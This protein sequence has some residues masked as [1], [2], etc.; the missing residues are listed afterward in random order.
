[1]E[2]LTN[3]SVPSLYPEPHVIKING[4]SGKEASFKF[5][6]IHA[7]R[8]RMK[9]NEIEIDQDFYLGKYP[10]TQEQWMAIM[11]KNPSHFKGGRLPVETVSW[12]DVQTFIQKLNTL[13]GKKSYR[14]PTEPEWE[15]ACRAGSTSAYFFGDDRNQLGEYVWYKDNSGNTTHPVGQKKPNEWGLHDMAGNVWEWTENWYDRSFSGRVIRGGC[16]FSYIGFCRSDYR[17]RYDPSF[18]HYYFGFRLAFVP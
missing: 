18:R 6:P 9:S 10:V 13:T 17:Y 3:E 14:L 11:G 7:G 8:F 4:L 2:S 5:C 12:D 1:M 15:Y 16:W